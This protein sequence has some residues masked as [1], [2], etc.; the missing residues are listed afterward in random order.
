MQ[1]LFRAA[2]SRRLKP[3]LIHHTERNSRYRAHAHQE[4]INYF[5]MQASTGRRDGYDNAPIESFRG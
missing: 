4:L 1:A 5:A 3:S 2:S